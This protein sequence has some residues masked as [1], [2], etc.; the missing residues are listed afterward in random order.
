[1]DKKSPDAFRTISEVA[2]WL[3]VPTHVLRFWESR[4]TQVKP[5]KRAGGRRYYRPADMELLGGIRKLL[6][7]DGMTIRGVQKLLRENGVKH[8]AAMS[9][10]LDSDELRDPDGSNVVSMTPAAAKAEAVVEERPAAPEAEPEVAETS[11][12]TQEVSK[13]TTPSEAE[14]EPAAAALDEDVP[15]TLTDAPEEVEEQSTSSASTHE[16]GMANDLFS[17]RSEETPEVSDP[18][19]EP[20]V[21]TPDE[22][23]DDAQVDTSADTEAESSSPEPAAAIPAAIDVSHVPS[24]TPDDAHAA[25][26]SASVASQLRALKSSGGALPDGAAYGMLARLK[27]LAQRMPPAPSDDGRAE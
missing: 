1:M 22:A 18:V 24:D 8:V 23:A 19:S 27:E 11:L 13:D 5:V 3:G 10:P 26:A 9:T 4:F 14:P 25:A 21:A 17:G 6:H 16:P 20:V 7:E 12:P 15:P 2:D